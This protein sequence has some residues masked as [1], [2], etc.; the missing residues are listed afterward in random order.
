[1]TYDLQITTILT[2]TTN[3]PIILSIIMAFAE[4]ET[5]KRTDL[6]FEL[7]VTNDE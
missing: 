5:N 1:M 7:I 4:A 6:K 3:D 2:I